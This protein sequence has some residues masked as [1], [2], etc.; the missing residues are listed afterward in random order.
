MSLLA[1]FFLEHSVEIKDVDHYGTGGTSPPNIWTG[2]PLFEESSQVKLSLYL[3]ISSHFISS[4]H[5]IVEEA[6]GLCPQTPYRVSAILVEVVTS[7]ERLR[8]E[9]LVWLIGAVVC[10]L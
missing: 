8:G 9:G 1:D 4:K 6:F 2:P 5:N 10:L 7:D 3:F